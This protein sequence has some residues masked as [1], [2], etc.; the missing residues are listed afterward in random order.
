MKRTCRYQPCSKEFTPNH[1]RQEFCEPTC[2][3]SQHYLEHP[4]KGR[5]LPGDALQ[6]VATHPL[7]DARA[8][9]EESE[10]NRQFGLLI[11][12]AIVDRLKTTGTCHADDLEPLYPA[13][14]LERKRCRRLAGAQFGSLASSKLI[15][16]KERRKSSVPA[17]KGAKSGVYEFTK[18]GWDR[19]GTA[20]VSS[21][22]TGAEPAATAH[23]GEES[24][25][26]DPGTIGPGGALRTSAPSPCASAAPARLPGL[27]ESSYERIQDA[28]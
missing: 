15:R 8:Q 26:G 5:V 2:R 19:W 10:T 9:Q 25:A 6:C 16:E 20:G 4:E 3:A 1:P 7:A 27:E 14:E 21:G 24:S 17:R 22:R 18:A 13:N 11:R 28:A 23:S 12:Q